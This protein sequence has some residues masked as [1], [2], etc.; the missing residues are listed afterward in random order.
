MQSKL[1]ILTLGICIATGVLAADKKEKPAP[2]P[3][4]PESFLGITLSGDVVNDL[5]KCKASFS[6]I[7]KPEVE[8]LCYLWPHTSK[9]PKFSQ[10]PDLGFHYRLSAVMFDGA[11]QHIILFTRTYNYRKLVEIFVAKYG[12]PSKRIEEPFRVKGVLTKYP[13]EILSWSGKSV[14]L[15]LELYNYDGEESSAVFTNKAVAEKAVRARELEVNA[16]ASKL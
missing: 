14:S 1:A 12:P 9:N 2:W 10:L 13:N 15:T 16:A 11:I 4:E 8:P 7:F 6:A 3:K 5:P